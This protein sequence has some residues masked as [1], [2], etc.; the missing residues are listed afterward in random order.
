MKFIDRPFVLPAIFLSM[1]LLIG[2]VVIGWGIS[3]RGVEN[4]IDVTGS[5]SQNAV[6]DE[7][8]WTIDI[9]QVAYTSSIGSVSNIVA[10]DADAIAQYLSNQKLASSTVATAVINTSE[11]YSN[12]GTPAN[13]TISDSVTVS[14]SDVNAVD[15]LSHNIGALNAVVSSNTVVSPES[16]Q[17]FISNLAALRIALLGDAIKDARAR[18]TQ[19]AQSGGS[20]VGPLETASSGVVQVSAPDS[21]NVED[22][23]QYDTSTIEK[24]VTETVRAS[25][26]VH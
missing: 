14:T 6:A 24:Q 3:G 26:Y 16:P 22:S 20:N 17:Y 10:N 2:L 25:F 18:A 13:Y 8:T 9:Q 11:N 23:G 21:A 15:K 1:A 19:I 4:T 5:A 12:N 7:A